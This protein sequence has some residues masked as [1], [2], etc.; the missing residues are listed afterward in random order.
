MDL[1]AGSLDQTYSPNYGG[2]A[3]PP[4]LRVLHE[5]ASGVAYLHNQDLIHRDIKP[6][7]ILLSRDNP[8]RMKVADYGHSKSTTPETGTCSWSG[9][10]GTLDYHSAEY[11]EW[12]DEFSQAIKRNKP[13][14]KW[15]TSNK[16]DVFST[17]IV[18]FE[19]LS[20]G[21]QHPFGNG[22]LVTSNIA[23]GETVDFDGMYAI[24]NYR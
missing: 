5:I 20:R 19:V 10:F 21:H 7:N 13:L 12:Q 17:G 22:V 9:G 4:P 15:R 24:S 23:T 1:C 2:P 3:L 16:V 6:Q 18:F 8:V 14:P 11:A